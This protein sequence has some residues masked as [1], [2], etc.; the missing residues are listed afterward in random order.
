MQTKHRIEIGEAGAMTGVPDASVDLIVTSPPYPM[1]SMWDQVFGARD[2]E[3]AK[4]LTAEDGPLAFERMHLQLD[5]VWGECLRVLRIG[6]LAC[7]NI[8]DAVRTIAGEFSL[9]SNHARILMAAARLGF[10]VLPDI[11]WRKP[12]NAP[13]KFMGSGML[14]AGA[15]VTYEHEYILILRKG[16]KRSFDHP[17]EKEQRRRSAFFWEERNEWFSDIWLNLRGAWQN[18]GNP[19]ARARSAA[20]PLELP[21]RL[22]Q[23]YSLIGDVVLDPFAGTGT[24]LA[25][26]VASA[27]S[28][29]GVEAAPELRPEIEAALMGAPKATRE[30]VLDRLRSHAAFVAGRAE[31]QK[32]VKHTNARYEFPVVTGQEADL[33]LFVAAA[34]ARSGPNTFTAHHEIAKLGE[35]VV[36]EEGILPFG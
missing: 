2:P 3:I 34:I 20:F 12:T 1:V 21:Y 32:E 4:A 31:A 9:Y 6:G 14:P 22:I 23:M 10:T 13:N 30:R 25:A 24:T 17:R 8:G 29:I 19:E 26:A 36:E 28:S 5:R 15:Y 35:Q 16:P 7:I 27:R 11:L 33:E 18:L